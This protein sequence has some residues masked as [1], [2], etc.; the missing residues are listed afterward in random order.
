MKDA[1][2]PYDAPETISTEVPASERVDRPGGEYEFNESENEV[3]RGMAS[4]M[5][6]IGIGTL[7]LAMLVLAY[8]GIV[9]VI[10]KS[11]AILFAFL[12]TSMLHMTFGVLMY[13]ASR[14]F[15]RIIH[16]SGEDIM[17]LINALAALTR[18][19]NIQCVSLILALLGTVMLLVAALSRFA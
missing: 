19:Y 1:Q 11:G 9:T 18:A 6:F 7:I 14:P 16:T 17:N 10:T 3:I 13:K 12:F 15:Y 4:V 2:N 5:R 8:G